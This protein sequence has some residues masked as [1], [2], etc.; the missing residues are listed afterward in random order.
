[1]KKFWMFLLMLALTGPMIGC[2]AE[3]EVDIDEDDA[4]LEI[5]VDD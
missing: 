4:K 3:G 1:M 2:E 5:D